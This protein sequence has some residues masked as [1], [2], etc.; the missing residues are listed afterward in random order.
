M[1]LWAQNGQVNNEIM[2]MMAQP[3]PNSISLW[4]KRHDF[5]QGRF[6][7]WIPHDNIWKYGLMT[8]KSTGVGSLCTN[9]IAG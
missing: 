6:H 5:L 3:L 2:E 8:L 7:F 9:A 4:L 1:I